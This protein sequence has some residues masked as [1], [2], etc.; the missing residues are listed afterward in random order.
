[1]YLREKKRRRKKR[2]SIADSVLQW[3]QG[4]GLGWAKA[5]GSYRV[6]HMSAKPKHQAIFSAFPGAVAGS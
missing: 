3:P 6:S 2:S 5:T 4:L 1:M